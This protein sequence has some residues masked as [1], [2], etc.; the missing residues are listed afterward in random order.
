MWMLLLTPFKSYYFQQQLSFH[1]IESSSDNHH[2][3]LFPLHSIC[4]YSINFYSCL[5]NNIIFAICEIKDDF[6]IPLQSYLFSLW[7][8]C[9]PF[10]LQSLCQ[11]HFPVC[12]SHVALFQDQSCTHYRV[13]HGRFKKI[14]TSL[15]T[16]HLASGT[17]SDL[18]GYVVKEL[19]N[20]YIS[21]SDLNSFFWHSKRYLA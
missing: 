9:T 10:Q 19:F 18:R 3:V 17:R 12:G 13:A 11:P 20:Q 7:I 16:M 4:N 21:W 8:P 15:F 6:I 1:I 2:S 5:S 14:F